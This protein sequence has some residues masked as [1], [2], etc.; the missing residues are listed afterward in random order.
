M[1]YDEDFIKDFYIAVNPPDFVPVTNIINV[2]TS[3]TVGVPLTITGTVVPNNATNKTIVWSL[4]EAGETGATL[5]GSNVLNTVTIGK[6]IITATI[7]NGIGMGID[8]IKDFVIAVNSPGFVPVLDIINV[9]KSTIV[10]VPLTITGT[11]IP[12][13]A[14]YK[15]IIWSLKS[16]G[17]T[18]ATLSD[19]NILNTK[20][21]GAAIVLATIENGKGIGIDF[22][23]E[24]IIA[25]NPEDFVPVIDIIDVPETAQV[26]I[27]LILTGTVVPSNA[28]YQT[29]VWKIKDTNGTKATLN[30]GNIFTAKETGTAIIEA[31]IVKGIGVNV[32][33]VKEFE[34]EVEGVGITEI[35]H[36]DVLKAY[37]QNGILYVSGLTVGEIWQV[38]DIF[39][40]LV[41]QGIATEEKENISLPVSGLYIIRS[42]E[43][44]AKVIND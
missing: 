39:G 34:I 20:N 4:K 40:K 17:S 36:P 26:N 29:I 37:K 41:F 11:V 32:N 5:S 18:G 21:I 43:K 2:P 28:T 27:P 14:T 25:V 33:F 22:T 13:N 19:S 42:I 12:S 16:A 30:N 31:T 1:W 8:F 38:Y 15:T 35:S 44:S 10:G 6:V 9:P 3:T 24:F 23:K 7:V